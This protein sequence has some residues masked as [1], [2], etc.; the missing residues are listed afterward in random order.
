MR[1]WCAAGSTASP[2]STGSPASRYEH[3]HPS[4][5]SHVDVTKF[6]NV[7]GGGG[8]R[9][10]GRAQGARNRAA[11]PDKPRNSYRNPKIGTAFVHTALDDHS[12]LAYAEIHADETAVTATAVLRRA[13]TWFATRGVTIE[14]VLS[15]PG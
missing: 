9:F 12:R 3:D 4:A 15:P 13:V 2:G 1:C 6:G 8:H 7:P 14:R 5:L 11:T 10:V